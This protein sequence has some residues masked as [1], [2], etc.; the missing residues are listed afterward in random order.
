MPK[1]TRKNRA[2]GDKNTR[3]VKLDVHEVSFVDDGANEEEQFLTVKRKPKKEKEK[4]GDLFSEIFGTGDTDSGETEKV[5]PS[6]VIQLFKGMTE[7]IE[8]L[9]KQLAAIG[10]KETDKSDS[11]DD[12]D[13]ADDAATEKAKRMTNSRLAKIKTAYEKL[14][15]L[16]E[17]IEANPATIAKRESDKLRE[18]MKS[19]FERVGKMFTDIEKKL[20]AKSDDGAA[21]KSDDETETD[22][23]ETDDTDDGKKTEKTKKETDDKETEKADS[24]ETPD[25][26]DAEETEKRKPASP[27]RGFFGGTHT[28]KSIEKHRRA[29]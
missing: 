13:S 20:E 6:K 28:G 12:D 27:F 24:R 25:D 3:F 26:G 17:E 18:E 23:T 7:K 5:D 10:S 11:A 29:K 22:K 4:M 16:I 2:P 1:Q 21:G 8:D 14:G 9:G 15:E 19:A